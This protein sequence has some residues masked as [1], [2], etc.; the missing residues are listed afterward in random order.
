MHIAMFAMRMIVVMV[1]VMI[2][3]VMVVM[4]AVVM[5]VIMAVAVFVSMAVRV[6]VRALDSGFTLAASANSTHQ[7]TSNSRIFNS[8]PPVTCN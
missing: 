2:M 6:A 1:V 4:V 7:Q 8:S 5:A 3:V